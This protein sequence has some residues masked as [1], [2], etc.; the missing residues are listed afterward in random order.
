MSSTKT[1]PRD[2]SSY[3]GPPGVW[4]NLGDGYAQ[5]VSKLTVYSRQR[6]PQA[7]SKHGI[8]HANVSSPP[9]VTPLIL[10]G[11][12]LVCGLGFGNEYATP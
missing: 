6:Q 1:T 12:G 9:G 2:F 7:R 5:E 8:I 11:G 3:E 4:G 10:Q